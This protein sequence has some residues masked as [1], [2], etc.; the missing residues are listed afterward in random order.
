M[1]V[2]RAKLLLKQQQIRLQI[3][4]IAVA[5]RNPLTFP[6]HSQP[7]ATTMNKTDSCQPCQFLHNHIV[8]T[9]L[10]IYCT[11]HCIFYDPD[12]KMYILYSAVKVFRAF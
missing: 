2:C 5:E 7:N 8:A 12:S 1:Y 11:G 10:I 6:F 3:K 9:E 4:S